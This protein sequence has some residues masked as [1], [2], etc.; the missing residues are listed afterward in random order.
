MSAVPIDG[1]FAHA[2]P[3]RPADRAQRALFLSLAMGLAV[4][5]LVVLALAW[6]DTLPQG[7]RLLADAARL[8]VWS[9]STG[10]ALAAALAVARGRVV[11]AAGLALA[12][13]PLAW[14]L[15]HEV[16]IATLATLTG[17]DIHGALSWLGATVHAVEFALLAV[18]LSVLSGRRAGPWPHAVAGAAAGGLAWA[19]TLAAM[20]AAATGPAVAIAETGV[21][22]GTA[23]VVFLAR[24]IGPRPA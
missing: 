17:R 9:T 13:A 15:A 1:S 6:Q 14:L 8:L 22:T 24:R 16:Q 4:Q 18:L 2:P 12:L 11:V 3:A 5:A 20:P 21:A 7:P 23:L 19:A 10:V